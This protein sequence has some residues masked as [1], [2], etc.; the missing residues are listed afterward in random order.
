ML[1]LIYR[2]PRVL[3]SIHTIK[4]KTGL[5]KLVLYIYINISYII[6]RVGRVCPGLVVGAANSAD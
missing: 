4:K 6:Y 3:F 5:A 2:S 1:T